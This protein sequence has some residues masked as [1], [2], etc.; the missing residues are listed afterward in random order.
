[1]SKT[2][3][4][5]SEGNSKYSIGELTK[6]AMDTKDKNF[7]EAL[8]HAQQAV[9]MALNLD[10]SKDICEAFSESSFENSIVPVSSK[11][12]FADALH[13][14]GECESENSNFTKAIFYLE[15]AEKIYEEIEDK[16]G[17]CETL[18]SLGKILINKGDFQEALEINLRALKISEEMNDTKRM[19][20]IMNNI[21]F[22]YWNLGD[23]RKAFT[24]L[25]KSLDFRKKFGDDS[26]I[27]KNLNNLGIVYSAM[28][29]FVSSLQCYKEA[30][31]IVEKLGQKKGVSILYMNIGLLYVK[32]NDVEKAMEYLYKSLEINK[33]INYKKGLSESYVNIAMV[34]RLMNDFEEALQ[35]ADVSLQIAEELGDKKVIAFAY[36]EIFKTFE[37]KKDYVKALEFGWKCY[38][39]RKDIE[40]KQGVMESCRHLCN[41][42]LKTG[43]LDKVLPLINEALQICEEADF[44]DHRQSI[45]LI[46]AEYYGKTNEHK[47]A[48]DYYKLYIDSVSSLYSE[49]ARIKIGNLQAIFEIEQARRE[50]EIYKLKNID[51]AEANKKLE[52]MNQEKNEFLNLVSHDL[53]NPLNSIYG[54]SNLL[55]ED[56]HTLSMGEISD[57]ASNINISSMAMLD[58]INEILNSELMDSGRY[59][60]HNELIDLNTMV[61]ALI[62]MNKFQLRQKDIKVEFDDNVIAH[63][64]SD[65]NI[66]KQVISN[67]LSNAI[68]F[69]PEGKKIFIS[70][71][72]NKADS[73]TSVE[74]KDEG[75]GL[76]EEDKS[77]MFV[78]FAK[79][80]AKPT[81]GESST[82]LGLSI[83]KKLTDI[84]G[85]KIVCES[86][87]GKGASFI[88]RIPT[89]P[90]K[91]KNN[92]ST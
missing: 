25:S 30:C 15:K 68:K 31:S 78:K 23:N 53:K 24:F 11:K 61:K 9:R 27:A 92:I 91:T 22:N 14:L 58:L 18:I 43:E 20:G 28:G 2:P 4:N 50:S 80:S 44:K 6:L 49:E 29:D 55:V 57:F 46:L 56:I 21:G 8:K 32:L 62:S 85:G 69:S 64:F 38:Y 10:P 75:P 36:Q 74:I 13:A 87:L 3:L 90:L 65:A 39:L 40:H 1:M 52:E 84:I 70:I 47:K 35:N 89:T 33:E 34:N 16:K 76:S 7:P 45:Y 60:L 42:F 73:S 71:L 26:D 63:V 19:M 66:V 54:F 86:E 88:L 17:T 81:A 67:I 48:N 12:E 72:H 82:G 79:L 77:K 83:V 37:D 5:I 41:L 51:L 59:E